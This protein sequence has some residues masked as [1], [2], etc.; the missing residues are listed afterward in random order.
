MPHDKL[1]T[2]LLTEKVFI[3][4]FVTVYLPPQ[5]DAGTKTPLTQLYKAISKQDM[6][7]QKWRFS[8][9]LILMQGN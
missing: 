2:M 3:C 7:I 4:F 6:H 1:Q 5:T 8:W 9:S